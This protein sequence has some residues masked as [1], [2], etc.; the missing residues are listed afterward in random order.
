MPQ[1]IMDVAMMTEPLFAIELNIRIGKS[2]DIRRYWKN[3]GDRI[4]RYLIKT[5]SPK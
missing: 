5:L 3:T 2:V 4:Q 1:S